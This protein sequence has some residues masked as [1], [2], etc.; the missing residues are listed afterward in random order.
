M[1]LNVSIAHLTTLVRFSLEEYVSLEGYKKA[2]WP[3]SSNELYWPS[4]RRLSA[5]LVPT[6][7]DRGCRVVS[8]T[9][10]YGRILRFLDR[11]RYFSSKQLLSCT[12]E[13]EGTPFQT[14]YLSE[15]LLEL[16]IEP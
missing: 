6:F 3:E 2:P 11:Y 4:D 7:A 5:K 15:N 10:P 8:M 13:A 9:D 1:G 16:G 14:R 12:H